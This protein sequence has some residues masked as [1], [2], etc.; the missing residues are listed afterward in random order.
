MH[1]IRSKWQSIKKRGFTIVELLVVI[2]IIGVL[3]TISIV[4]YSAWRQTTAA[5][6][7]KNDLNA[8]SSA[9]ETYRT[10]NNGY[11]SDLATI[12]STF[13][14]NPDVTITPYSVGSGSYCYDAV[15]NSFSS[16]T[17]YLASETKDSPLEGTCATRP[18][19]TVPAAPTNLAITSASA[20]QIAMSWTASS[21]AASYTLQCA[22]DSAFINGLREATS[23]GLTGTV[24]NL[25]AS[26]THFCRIK[27]LNGA[28]SST[29][30]S[31]VSTD[32][33][34]LAVPT[35]VV[36]SSIN[37]ISFI[38]SW[39]ANTDATS[40]TAQCATNVGFT[41]GL[42][43]ITVTAPTVQFNSRVALTT[44][45][46]RVRAQ[47]ISNTSAWSTTLT[48]TT[49]ATFGTIAAAT[50]LNETAMTPA[51]ATA[52]W[53]GITCSLGSPEY[54]FMWVSPQTSGTGWSASTSANVTFPQQTANTW[55]VESRCVYLTA[56]SSVTSS[57]N[58]SFTSTGTADPAGAFGTIGWN[59]RFQF[60][61]NANT[62][63]CVSPATEQYQLVSTLI[64]ATTSTISYGWTG[65]TVM[66][67]TG[68]NQG[69]RM[70]TYIQVRCLYNSIPSNV[71]AT[72]SRTDNASIDAPGSVPGWCAGTCGSPRGDR[73]SAV[74]CPAGT[75]ASY[76]AY[77]VG[78][79]SNPIW[80]AYEATGFFGYDRGYYST[81][82]T[83]VNGYLKARCITS[84]TASAYGPQSYAYY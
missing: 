61:T 14:A 10:F 53:T 2:A 82:D 47:N 22:S 55:R 83:M 71:I 81:G 24:T 58:K 40:F 27:A 18:T 6:Q 5:T 68:V 20:A 16:V 38:L 1:K 45:Y 43:E 8:L 64:N 48:V 75:T 63:A 11:P 7:V 52:N 70:T 57:S 65:T 21:G 76:W 3:A 60:D 28:G 44:Y 4:G 29:F 39:D 77:A 50:G 15:A 59:G 25:V 80:G 49:T 73:W 54:R 74:S 79:Y 12:A 51:T 46:C 32:T 42:A 33:T 62:Y 23:T 31:T 26:S 34:I 56:I 69:S 9:M 66:S 30:T 84:Y 41:T 67:V 72:S 37:D 17:Y 78:N 36:S 35:S 13:T 19:L